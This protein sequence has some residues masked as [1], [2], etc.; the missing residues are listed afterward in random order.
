MTTPVET[1]TKPA[2]PLNPAVEK[3]NEKKVTIPKSEGYPLFY[4][5]FLNYS[6]S[7]SFLESHSRSC[8]YSLSCSL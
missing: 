5:H 8:Q 6:E 7:I 3:L 1:T 4:L 2:A